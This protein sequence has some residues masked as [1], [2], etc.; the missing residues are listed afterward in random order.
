MYRDAAALNRR[1]DFF[2]DDS[3]GG[4]ER[5]ITP[6]KAVEAHLIHL[7]HIADQ[8]IGEYGFYAL[9]FGGRREELTPEAGALLAVGGDD[10]DI[11]RAGMVVRG[12]DLAVGI[13]VRLGIGIGIQGESRADDLGIGVSG[14]DL[15]NHALVAVAELIHDIG[16]QGGID[17][18]PCFV[19]L[20]LLLLA[21]WV[22]ALNR[23]TTALVLVDPGHQ[24]RSIAS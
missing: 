12:E 2:G 7:A 22:C 19:H 23:Q 16:G 10:E 18:L 15:R 11:A 3:A 20:E 5:R 9:G 14:P 8:A 13:G 4:V 21:L 6:A 17:G 1:I 24:Q